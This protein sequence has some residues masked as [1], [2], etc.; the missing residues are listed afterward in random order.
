VTAPD[1]KVT[2]CT[3]THTG[4]PIRIAL[5]FLSFFF[6]CV[7]VW[8]GV[9]EGKNKK[10]VDSGKTKK[11]LLGVYTR[12]KAELSSLSV[13]VPALAM[14]QRRGRSLEASTNTREKKMG[15]R[16]QQQQQESLLC[17]ALCSPDGNRHPLHQERERER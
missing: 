17:G 16:R 7:C 5:F 6:V 8:K 13:L 11:Q 3:H 14:V 4:T 9:G 15:R 2:K 10:K 12:A 1:P